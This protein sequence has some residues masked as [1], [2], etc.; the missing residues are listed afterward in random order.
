MIDSRDDNE[1]VSEEAQGGQSIGKSK[2]KKQ[3]SGLA[4][5]SYADSLK[6]SRGTPM[7]VLDTLEEDGEESRETTEDE[8]DISEKG[9]DQHAI[10]EAMKNADIC[11]T[12]EQRIPSV[13]K[14]DRVQDL[15]L[16]KHNV[17]PQGSS[18]RTLEG[19]NLSCSNFFVV[20]DNDNICAMAEDMGVAICDEYFDV[21]EIMKDLEIAR[22][23]Q[24]N[25][26]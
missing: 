3:L 19:T 17:T 5:G 9:L 4:R 25:R 23:A 18:K 14:S 20:S 15:M 6:S 10:S 13:R 2:A 11:I 12:E 7:I 22:H 26:K 16:K 8:G 24:I 21:A 1:W